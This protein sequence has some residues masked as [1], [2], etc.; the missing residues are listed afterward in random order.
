MAEGHPA[1]PL[2]AAALEQVAT[3]LT[4]KLARDGEGASKLLEVHVGGAATLQD[5]RLAAKEIAK[6]MLLKAAIFGADPNWGRVLD[7]IGYCGIDVEEARLTLVL[8][9]VEVFRKG[10]PVP[11]E[12][13][14]LREALAA[15][16]VDVHVDLGAGEEHA[17]AWGCDLTPEYVRINSEFTT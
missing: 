8:Q 10:E 3:T 14:E 4:R 13:A 2:L 1:L 7:S 16:E 17:T 12:D 9:G 5:A 15:P 6:S 11:F